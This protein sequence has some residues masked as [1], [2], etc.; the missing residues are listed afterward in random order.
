[1]KAIFS[2]QHRHNSIDF[3]LLFTRLGV[4]LLMLTHGLPKIA[5]LQS[6]PVM[7]MDFLGLGTTLSL[8]L[9]IF[10]EVICS[11][12]IIFGLGTRLATIPLMITMLVAVF[13]VHSADPFSSKEMGLHYLLSYVMLLI[14]GSGKYSLDAIIAKKLNL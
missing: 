6:E 5:L 10:A 13:I 7:F 3:A 1:M 9:A 8:L 12:F 11:L 14:M 2:V 4:G